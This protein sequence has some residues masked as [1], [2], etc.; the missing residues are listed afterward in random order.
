VVAPVS[1]TAAGLSLFFNVPDFAAGRYLAILADHASAGE[2]GE[3]EKP[4][5]THHTFFFR[6]NL[7]PMRLILI[8]DVLV[9]IIGI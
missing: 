3:A 8:D 7:V 2:S 6:A 5:E 1:V 4:N 9:S